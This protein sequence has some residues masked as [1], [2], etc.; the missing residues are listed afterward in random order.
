MTEEQIKFFCKCMVENGNRL[1][2]KEEKEVLK[3]A[4]DDAKNMQQL[5]EIAIASTSFG[6]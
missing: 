2:T 1:F 5:F 3:H 6:R 4:I